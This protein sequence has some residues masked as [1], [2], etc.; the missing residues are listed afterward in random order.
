MDIHVIG[1]TCA[2]I[3]LDIF[4]GLAQ[5]AKNGEISST[6]MR[7]GLWHKLGFI[8]AI[9]LASLCEF[10]EN[11]VDLGFAIPLCAPVCVFIIL[12]EIVSILENLGKLSPELASSEFLK[13]F[14]NDE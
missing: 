7:D 6:K 8:G 13:Y 4:C 14:K 10:S 5:A 9:A 12:T 2:F 11:I 1:V 3:V